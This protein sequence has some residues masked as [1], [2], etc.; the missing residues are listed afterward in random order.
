MSK[1]RLDKYLLYDEINEL[2]HSWQENY[3]NLITVE[4]IGQSYEGRDVWALTITNKNTGSPDTK[5][6]MYVDANI[7]AG[8]VTGS[9][10]ALHLAEYLLT[11][12]NDKIKKLL[13]TRTFYILPRINPDGAELYL[14]TPTLLRSSVRPF[15]DFRKDE[16]PA[17]LHAF[18][19]NGD[20]R[21]QLMR[22]RDDQHGAW[23][24]SS[25]DPRAMVERSP[26]DLEGPF[27]HIY[28]EGHL[29]DAQG[30]IL[31]NARY[32]FEAVDTKYGLDLN[33]NFP[34][35][36]NPL[37]PGSGPFPLSE[38]ETRNQ[39]EFI[40]KHSNIGGV[41][42]Y[43]T[44]GGVLFRPHSTVPDKNFDKTD[45]AMYKELGNIGTKTTSY[46]VVCCYGDIW[47]GVLD[48]WCFEY[49][50]LFAFTPELW[51]AVGRAAPEVKKDPYKEP[52]KEELNQL[53]IKL[54][55]WN[56]RELSG[57]G[58]TAWHKF[59]HPQF[60]SIEI[61]GWKVKECRQNPP[62]KFLEQECYKM[63][64]FALGYALSLPV[65]HIDEIEVTNLE[66]NIYQIEA[67]VSNHGFMNTNISEQA[68]KQKAVRQDLVTLNVSETT[69]LIN[70]DFQ[71]EIGFLEGYSAGQQSRFY[72]FGKPAKSGKR[73]KWTIQLTEAC[74]KQISITLK[75]ER[76]GVKTKTIAL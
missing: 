33:R 47:S 21:I 50:G 40:N 51:D 37:T 3:P 29:L 23:K 15:P 43:H 61:G 53:E 22:I 76:G 59:D 65:V 5:P 19:I 73:I 2:M 16:D 28:T 46:P 68:K 10:A 38:P 11:T 25:E 9:M 49:K 20:G 42:L 6:A 58:F 13:D 48:D 69:S 34:A 66:N 24:I 72:R 54:L 62:V 1:L 35:G 36:Y 75:S 64:Q 12:E 41:L 31:E 17:G 67:V 27:Y 55:Q 63:T 52:S 39:V 71:V 18:D 74:S 32:P 4:T 56:D 14:T 70:G 45:L 57:Q 7:H 60:G 30:N 8:E 26:L 44:T